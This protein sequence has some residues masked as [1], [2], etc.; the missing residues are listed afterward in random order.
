MGG[1]VTEESRMTQVH[2]SLVVGTGIAG[3]KE[4]GENKRIIF[5][6]KTNIGIGST[7]LTCECNF[8][9][10]CIYQDNNN[11]NNNNSNSSIAVIVIV[12]V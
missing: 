5:P 11:N 3:K 9:F 1:L 4:K 7:D 6:L 2:R 8:I 12:V 10:I